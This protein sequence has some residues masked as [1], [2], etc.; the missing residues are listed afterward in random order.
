MPALSILFALALPSA[1]LDDAG[2]PLREHAVFSMACAYRKADVQVFVDSLRAT[3]FSGH[4]RFGVD[5]A[6]DEET[7]GYLAAQRVTTDHLPC[8]TIPLLSK[9]QRA[10]PGVWLGGLNQARYDHY[11][12]WLDE[13]PRLGWV[14]LLDARDVLFLRHPFEAGPRGL[15]LFAEMPALSVWVAQRVAACFGEGVAREMSA[16]LRY[17]L[18]GGTVYGSSEA[19]RRFGRA[20]RAVGLHMGAE[21]SKRRVC[22]VNDQPL[23]NVLGWQQGMRAPGLHETDELGTVRLH[24]LWEGPALTLKTPRVCD[25]FTATGAGGVRVLHK[26]QKCPAARVL[27]KARLPH[28]PIR[29]AHS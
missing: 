24:G 20:M 23:L 15:S 8:E 19:I 9:A 2:D 21:G 5:R 14:W 18:C 7:R 10:A 22:R 3:G 27:A 13:G 16:Q 11:L 28:L 26:W 6:L 25:N 4:V 1:R 12:R 29:Q 17:N